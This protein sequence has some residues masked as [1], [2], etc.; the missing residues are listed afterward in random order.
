MLP[1]CHTLELCWTQ[2]VDCC[3]LLRAAGPSL[4][5]LNLKVHA[6]CPGCQQQSTWVLRTSLPQGCEWVNDHCILQTAMSSL[7]WLDVSY[8][9]IGDGTLGAVQVCMLAAAS[10][11]TC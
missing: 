8:T 5:R 4:R 11:L 3:K 10:R 9:A 1:C 6:L 2:H 7:K